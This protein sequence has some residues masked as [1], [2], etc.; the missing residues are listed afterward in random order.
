MSVLC[1]KAAPWGTFICQEWEKVPEGWW[2]GVSSRRVVTARHLWL[3]QHDLLRRWLLLSDPIYIPQHLVVVL[4][5]LL[6]EIWGISV[7]LLSGPMIVYE[8]M[9][10]VILGFFLSLHATVN[11]RKITQWWRSVSVGLCCPLL[12]EQAVV[13][14]VS[15]FRCVCSCYS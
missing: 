14:F 10:E 2:D 5:H 7:H 12:A 11:K 3:Q 1:V 6:K 9:N 15:A 4:L 13:E 8:C